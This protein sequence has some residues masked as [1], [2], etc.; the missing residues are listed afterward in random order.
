VGLL[1][2]V[3]LLL[4]LGSVTQA[5]LQQRSP[6]EARVSPVLSF[7]ERMRRVTYERDCKRGSDCEPPLACLSDV[8]LRTRYCTDSECTTDDQCPEGQ[9]CQSLPT[10]DN[11][12]LVRY[13]IPLGVRKEGEGCY[14]PPGDKESACGPGLVC[15]G[16]ESWCG[17]PC[18]KDEAGSCPE[19]FFCAGVAP[20]PA[21][22]PTCRE[23]GCPEGQHCVLFEEDVS[24]CAVVYGPNCQQYPC[25]Q[26]RECDVFEV[27]DQP[28]KVWM[29]CVERCGEG[30]PPCPTGRACDM[31]RCQPACDPQAPGTCGAG[32]R[33]D[34]RKPGTPWVC[35]PDV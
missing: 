26:G 23:R 10:V 13:C 22:L 17:R 9:T 20:Q 7:E 35:L 33:C 12:P 29:E 32:Y 21:C 8:R 27:A 34:Q 3:P 16:K 11:G 19:G 1:L 30:W 15:A 31:V 28:D 24:R 4:L 25:P 14:R 6:E 18:R 2:P 5:K